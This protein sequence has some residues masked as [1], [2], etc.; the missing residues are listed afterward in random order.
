MLYIKRMHPRIF[1]QIV[2]ELN[3]E[4]YVLYLSDYRKV[5]FTG[6]GLSFF[7]LIIVFNLLAC[8]PI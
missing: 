5:R 7:K 8:I 4:E 2:V 1:E 3:G 6:E